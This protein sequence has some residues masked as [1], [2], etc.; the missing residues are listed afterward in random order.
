LSSQQTAQKYIFKIHTDRLKKARWK[1]RLTLA[2]ARENDEMISIGDSQML[3]WIDQINGVTDQEE[4]IRALRREIKALRKTYDTLT[5]R[6][7][8]RE[9]YSMIDAIQFKPDYMH[10]VVDKN[11]DYLRACRGFEINGVKYA[12]LLGTSGGIKNNTVVF[13]N[14]KL[15]AALRDKIDNGRNKDVPLVA[16]KLEAYRALTCSGSTPVSMPNGV[17][18]VKDCITRFKEDVLYLT[19]ENDG[20]PELREWN[21]FDV[22]L[23]ASDGC[24][25]MLPSLAERWSQELKL[26]Y[27]AGALNTRQSWEKGV[28]FAFDFIEFADRVAGTRIVKDAWG[29]DVDIGTVELVLTTSMLKLWNC[30]DSV[31]HYLAC[32][33]ENGYSFG[34]AKNAPRELEN[35]RAAN[36]QFLQCLEMTDEQIDRL[37]KP[38]V[39]EINDVMHGDYRKALLFMAGTRLDDNNVLRQPNYVQAVMANPAMYD[40]PFIRQK[41]RRAIRKRI[42]DAKIGVIDLHANYSIIGGDLYAL[43]QSMFGLEV[44]GLLKAG[45]LYN[46]YWDDAGP[47]SVV[48]FRAPMSTAENVKVMKVARDEAV[49]Y[50]FR[51]IPTCTLLNAWDTCTAA[52]NGCDF[53]GDILYVT[54]DPVISEVAPRLKTLYCAQKS[55]TKKVVEEADLIQS[56]IDGFGNEVG[57]VTNRVTSMYDV[58]AKYPPGSAE[59]ETVDYR[60][61]CGE[62]YQQNTIDKT[63]GI[64]CKQM[65]KYWYDNHSIGTECAEEDVEF[66][67]AVVASRKPYFM[68]YIYPQIMKD[69]R[70]F[71][72]KA[73]LS[74]LAKFCMSLDELDALPAD[75]RTEDMDRFLGNCE[76]FMPVGDHNCTMNRICR[77]VEQRMDGSDA[78]DTAPQ[79]FDCSIMKSGVKYN[80]HTYYSF[81]QL[82]DEHF[83]LLA[84]LAQDER[85]RS[86]SKGSQQGY[87]E[88]MAEEFRRKADAIFG[89]SAEKCDIA[90]DVCYHR[91]S[92]KQFAWD[93]AGDE[94]LEN[95]VVAAGGVIEY[96]VLDPDGDIEYRGE[97]YSMTRLE[98]AA[99]GDHPE[100]RGVADVGDREE[101]SRQEAGVHDNAVRQVPARDGDEQARDAQQN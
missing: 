4:R 8:I 43:C 13:V 44:T 40:D 94:I 86:N 36:Y 25:L 87:R 98:V 12:R 101:G 32:C 19:D 83:R 29:H 42:D 95:L 99:N 16:A 74:C 18:V 14:E 1:L 24:G 88:I 71:M 45:E 70:E 5:S 57:K 33:A 10:L 65:P 27:T 22:E 96:P 97:R 15:V 38:T 7:R 67:R 55:A 54:D 90:I 75:Q 92:A 31:E 28:V 23:N 39:D 66:Q 21:G 60:M 77:R 35:R 34:I 76:R 93:L 11:K 50:W 17:L 64:V 69:Y 46:K 84:D 41:I 100:R 78:E 52:L 63:K 6:R 56:N 85:S 61:Q 37:I 81:K 58:R 20:E 53:D 89:S 59:Y 72:R 82:Y 3:R 51:H 68:R 73:N 62:L 79:S 9:L 49:R 26:G 91:N 48:C 80:K 2:E 30:Y 47:E